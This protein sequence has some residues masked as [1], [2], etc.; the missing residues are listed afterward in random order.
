MALR[1]LLID[2]NDV[3]RQ[4]L[5]VLLTLRGD[6][7]IAGSDPDGED[8]LARCAEVRPD[9][10]L[11]DYRLPGLDGVELTS[12]V[13][14]ACPGVAVLCLTA[15]INEREEEAVRTAG[16]VECVLKDAPLDEIV[17]A[18]RRAAGR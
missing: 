6:I 17:E 10:L 15:E 1:V 11:V 16:A 4:A 18:I 5:E 12:A 7:E 14:F 13:R 8:V 3:F 9:V 2:D